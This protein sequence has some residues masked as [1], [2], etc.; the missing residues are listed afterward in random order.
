MKKELDILLGN[1]A[2]CGQRI[3][4]LTY[5]LNKNK[6]VFPL[7]IKTINSLTDDQE[8]SIDALILRYSQ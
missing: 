8:E 5:S 4:K 2:A 3:D 6:D 1:V 7:A